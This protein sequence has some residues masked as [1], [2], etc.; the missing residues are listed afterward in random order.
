MKFK[1]DL[2]QLEMYTV[3]CRATTDI[4]KK[5]YDSHAKTEKKME[6][7]KMLS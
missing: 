1:V 6:L 5:K 7:Y 2:N 4:L 3:N